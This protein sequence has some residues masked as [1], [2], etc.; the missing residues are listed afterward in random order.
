MLE[1]E[2]QFINSSDYRARIVLSLCEFKEAGYAAMKFQYFLTDLDRSLKLSLKFLPKEN[3]NFIYW[4][5]ML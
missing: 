1:N 5:L 3:E 2:S 4:Q